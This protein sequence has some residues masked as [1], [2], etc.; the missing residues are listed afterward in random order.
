MNTS[1]VSMKASSKVTLA[2]TG[3]M[4]S[5]GECFSQIIRF[6]MSFNSNSGKSTVY[7]KLYNRAIRKHAR[8]DSASANLLSCWVCAGGYC[9][10]TSHAYVFI[11]L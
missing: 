8:V 5:G 9:L 11:V 4:A 1:Y 6:F 3:E 2:R 10:M 7:E